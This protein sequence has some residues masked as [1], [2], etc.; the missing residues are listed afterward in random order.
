M[1]NKRYQIFNEKCVLII[2]VSNTNLTKYLHELFLPPI[3]VFI[4]SVLMYN[5]GVKASS[6]DGNLPTRSVYVYWR[7]QEDIA[8]R[9]L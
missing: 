2:C 4:M 6:R 8:A 3:I 9:F 5:Q 1:Y 7:Q